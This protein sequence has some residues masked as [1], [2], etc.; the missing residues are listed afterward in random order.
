MPL[1]E[2][3]EFFPGSLLCGR[4]NMQHNRLINNRL[5]VTVSQAITYNLTIDDSV[6]VKR[7]RL[8]VTVQ[9]KVPCKLELNTHAWNN[10]CTFP[11]KIILHNFKLGN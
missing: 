7:I 3:S 2:Y 5:P 8:T 10:S 11:K 6:L 4:V 1:T 9:Y